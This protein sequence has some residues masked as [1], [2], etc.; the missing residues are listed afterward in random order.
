[1]AN[2]FIMDDF[3]GGRIIKLNRP[4]KMNAI[5]LEMIK[6]LHDAFREMEPDRNVRCVIVTGNGKYFCA[7]ADI[8][9]LME[10]KTGE[11]S[12]KFVT[13]YQNLFK[14]ISKFPKP[15]IAA[16]RG[17]A[18]GGGLE[19]AISC[20]LLIASKGTKLG[21]P[22]VKLGAIPAGGGASRIHKIVGEKVAKEMLFLGDPL[23]VE[24]MHDL[25]LVNM[26][27]END[28]LDSIALKVGEKLSKLP[29]KAICEMKKLTRHVQFQSLD[30]GMSMEVDVFE[31]LW[32]LK[33]FKE[34][35]ESFLSKRAPVFNKD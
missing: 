35:V 24:R 32:E 25:G 28:D 30:E 14:Y 8:E 2:T 1:M 4:D 22:E 17:F 9:G 15:T 5:N 3:N 10:L 26:I 21:V 20:D 27:T 31:K 16:I 6:E 33:D 23:P 19:L 12:R 29:S 34:G 11:D 18:L 13:S 7:G